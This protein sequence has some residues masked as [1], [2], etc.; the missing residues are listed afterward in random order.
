MTFLVLTAPWLSVGLRRRSGP[1][2]LSGYAVVL[3]GDPCLRGGCKHV[4]GTSGQR[5]DEHRSVSGFAR[6]HPHQ[7]GDSGFAVSCLLS[8]LCTP[9]LGDDTRRPSL[10]GQTF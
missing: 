8:P 5:E 7:R 3:V 2:V 4:P 1:A 10:A 6:S 9:T